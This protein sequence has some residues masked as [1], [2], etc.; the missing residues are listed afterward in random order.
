LHFLLVAVVLKM[1]H[2][3]P[4]VHN[5]RNPSIKLF[6]TSKVQFSPKVGCALLFGNNKMIWKQPIPTNLETDFGEDML[7]YT[8]YILILL[9]ACNEDVVVNFGGKL[10]DLKRGQTI[11]GRN[12]WCEYLSLSPKGIENLLKRLEKV[13]SKVTCERTR[14]CTLITILNYDSIVSMSAQQ[15]AKQVPSKCQA[16]ATSKS[17]KNVKSVKSTREVDFNEEYLVSRE[18]YKKII[19]SDSFSTYEISFN[20]FK[21]YYPKIKDYSQST[22]KIYKN[23]EATIRNWIR[24]D[25]TRGTYQKFIDGDHK[26]QFTLLN[27]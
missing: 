2:T 10:V 17:V 21:E 25:I 1:C 11:F 6:S 7:V 3:I 18:L 24:N 12:K 13:P 8:L 20:R 22:G 16:S 15:S 26:D 9:R 23:F 19:M 4:D 27:Y 14:N 5:F